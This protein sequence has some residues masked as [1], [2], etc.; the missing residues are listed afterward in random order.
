MSTL[1]W[2]AYAAAFL[3]GLVYA[4]L[5]SMEQVY[6]RITLPQVFY[7]I[8]LLLCAT[9][10]GHARDLTAT[11][12]FL[13]I[14]AA[15]FCWLTLRGEPEHSVTLQGEAQKELDEFRKTLAEKP[16]DVIA[17]EGI[18][19]LY[20]KVGEHLYARKWYQK[21]VEVY[22]ANPAY[23]RLKISLEEKMSNLEI[24][25]IAGTDPRMPYF[26]RACPKCDSMAFRAQY[27]C[28]VCAE[29]FYSN[30]LMWRAAT[31]NRFFEKNELVRVT[32]A[33]V[34]FLPFLFYC[35]S[36]AYFVLLGIWSL[37]FRTNAGM[38]LAVQG[39][40]PGDFPRFLF[41]AGM[42]SCLL[43]AFM[44]PES[45]ILPGKGTKSGKPGKAPVAKEGPGNIRASMSPQVK[46][47]LTSALAK[48][49]FD[50]A[51][52]KGTAMRYA[53]EEM[54]ANN[55]SPTLEKAMAEAQAEGALDIPYL[56]GATL[57][58][59]L[60][61]ISEGRSSPTLEKAVALAEKRGDLDKPFAGGVTLKQIL[62][63]ARQGYAGPSIDKALAAAEAN[64]DLDK[65]KVMGKSLR[66]YRDEA[67]AL[68]AQADEK[69]RQSEA[70]QSE[71]LG[72]DVSPHDPRA[73]AA[74]MAG[75]LRNPKALA[76]DRVQAVQTLSDIR[77]AA[78]AEDAIPALEAAQN[79]P[80]QDVQGFAKIAL[81]RIRFC[82]N[83]TLCQSKWRQK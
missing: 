15:L 53:I 72:V 83:S 64:G 68:S 71:A 38:K 44:V 30:R 8:Y 23:Y 19:D 27:A 54:A 28:H 18:G 60:E 48:G 76:D 82:Q 43:I 5:A 41:R 62:N 21:L 13:A 61:E 80:D 10:V 1:P 12:A 47:A 59:V 56:K 26:L 65:I 29:P 32:Q 39:E 73:I 78:N 57:R 69:A 34:V 36:A 20:A 37:A 25:P 66:Q 14:P 9:I 52:P 70:A 3:V 81:Q 63:E 46:E 22:A 11:L 50:K 33:S 55:A 17:L 31:F 51:Y 74:E 2:L 49:D 58:Q 24:N 42:V 40:Q 16:K 77:I 67:L 7:L 35:G 6:E 75:I 4:I 79:D 45:R